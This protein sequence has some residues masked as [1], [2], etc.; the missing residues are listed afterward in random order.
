MRNVD[1]LSA[2]FDENSAVWVE[3]VQARQMLLFILV[4]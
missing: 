2:I 1:A 4:G 3:V